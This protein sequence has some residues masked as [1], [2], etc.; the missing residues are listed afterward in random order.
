M[1]VYFAGGGK[2]KRYYHDSQEFGV[3]T[4]WEARDNLLGA[5]MHTVLRN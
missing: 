2:K 3:S 4:R 5:I 1:R